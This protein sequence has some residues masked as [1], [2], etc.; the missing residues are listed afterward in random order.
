MVKRVRTR[1]K[2]LKTWTMVQLRDAVRDA[3]YDVF[4]DA[5]YKITRG[6]VDRS[7][8]ID[9]SPNRWVDKEIGMV[10]V[11]YEIPFET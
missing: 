3:V 11:N 2:S 7:I 9:K 6:G 1:R 8:Y 10:V 5:G 4:N